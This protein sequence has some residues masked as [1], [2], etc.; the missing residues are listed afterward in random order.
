MKIF[1]GM[2][3]KGGEERGEVDQF[4]GSYLKTGV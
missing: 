4:E 2:R 3:E 1:G